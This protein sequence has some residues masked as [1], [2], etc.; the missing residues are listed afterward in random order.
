[1]KAIYVPGNQSASEELYYLDEDG[2][3]QDE[4]LWDEILGADDTDVIQLSD[5]SELQSGFDAEW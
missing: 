2:V 4:E 3:A 1:L 5:V